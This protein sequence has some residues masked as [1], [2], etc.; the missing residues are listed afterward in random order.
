RGVGLLIL[1][2]FLLVYVFLKIKP[3]N[4]IIIFAFL[5]LLLLFL[6]Y[7]LSFFGFVISYRGEQ[8]VWYL[9]KEAYKKIYT[10]SMFFSLFIVLILA[11]R[12]LKQFNYVTIGALV[13]VLGFGYFLNKK[14]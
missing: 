14:G 12:Y 6:L 3:D 4:F 2:A 7:F 8:R 11:L 9:K 5:I 1:S 10:N 13:V